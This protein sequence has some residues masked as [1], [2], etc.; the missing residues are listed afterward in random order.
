MPCPWNTRLRCRG[1]CPRSGFLKVE[2]ISPRGAGFILCTPCRPCHRTG[3]SGRR[4]R[5]RNS[6]SSALAGSR[7]SHQRGDRLCA[8]A[9][10]EHRDCRRWRVRLGQ[11]GDCSRAGCR[12]RRHVCAKAISA[13]D[14]QGA[15][16]GVAGIFPWLGRAR[17]KRIAGRFSPIS[18][19]CRRRRRTRR[20]SGRCVR[21]IFTSI[22]ERRL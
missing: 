4:L 17:A 22:S 6:R 10:E 9:G 21:R 5:S 7:G 19:T 14:Q 16:L 11:C 15:R 8:V 1:S 12:A 3:R 18:T 13:A 20:C 2:T